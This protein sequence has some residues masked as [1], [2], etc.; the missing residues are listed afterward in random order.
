LRGIE[1][2]GEKNLIVFLK[3]GVTRWLDRK[4]GLIY[5]R[6]MTITQTI[7]ITDDYEV[8]LKIP[9]NAPK[10]KANVII[11]FP[12]EEKP[13]AN[14]GIPRF[15]KKELDEILQRPHPITDSLSGILSGLG[16]VDLDEMRMERLSKHL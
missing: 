13:K 16:D 5:I 7:D 3:K 6:S 8:M 12:T 9:R 1:Y 11:Q 2:F 10:G 14:S 4:E 15:T